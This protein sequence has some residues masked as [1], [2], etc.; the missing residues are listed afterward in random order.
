MMNKIYEIQ[1]IYINGKPLLQ[2]SV[3]GRTYRMEFN[4]LMSKNEQC[5]KFVD[6]IADAENKILMEESKDFT[7]YIFKKLSI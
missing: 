6:Y 5:Q 7:D 2:S 3:N 1:L 4:L